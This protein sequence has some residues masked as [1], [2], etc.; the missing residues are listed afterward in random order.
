[1]FKFSDGQ[2]KHLPA[3]MKPTIPPTVQTLCGIEITIAP[4]VMSDE[5]ASVSYCPTCTSRAQAMGGARVG[6]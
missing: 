4:G 6:R 3:R 2:T 1:M 5:P